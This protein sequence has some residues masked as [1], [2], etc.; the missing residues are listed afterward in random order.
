MICVLLAGFLFGTLLPFVVEDRVDVVQQGYYETSFIVVH[1]GHI[2]FSLP[3]LRAVHKVDCFEVRQQFLSVIFIDP[4]LKEVLVKQLVG[5]FSDLG[6][7]P[8]LSLQQI[9]R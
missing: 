7:A 5:K 8:I 6:M 3:P 4:V 1:V 2:A 9:R